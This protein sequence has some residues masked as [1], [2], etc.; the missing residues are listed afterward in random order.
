MSNMAADN[1]SDGLPAPAT[2]PNMA[3]D[4]GSDGVPAPATP[5]RTTAGATVFWLEE[6]WWWCDG[7]WY[8]A[9]GEQYVAPVQKMKGKKRTFATPGPY[10][11]EG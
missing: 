5:P 9:E 10:S 11:K 8:N 4:N 3:A 1:G 2:P 6:D 7:H